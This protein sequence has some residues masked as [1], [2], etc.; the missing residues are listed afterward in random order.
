MLFEEFPELCR[1]PRSLPTRF[2]Q[3]SYLL[4]LAIDGLILCHLSGR[5]EAHSSIA[6]ICSSTRRSSL[7]SCL[8]NATAPCM[9]LRECPILRPTRIELH[10]TGMPQAARWCS[11]DRIRQ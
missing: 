7:V 6:S 10:Q 9:A 8:G 2:T 4:S 5:S 11:L 3:V 1:S